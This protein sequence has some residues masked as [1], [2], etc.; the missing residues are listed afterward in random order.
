MVE[1]S[2]TKDFEDFYNV[3]LEF[4]GWFALLNYHT[5]LLDTVGLYESFNYAHSIIKTVL[6]LPFENLPLYINLDENHEFFKGQPFKLRRLP[7]LTRFL[8]L[9]RLKAGK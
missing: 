9:E 2:I 4:N 8:I 3:K 1:L 5:K 6:A 7:E